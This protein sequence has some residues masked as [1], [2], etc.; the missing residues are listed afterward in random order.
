MNHEGVREFPRRNFLHAFRVLDSLCSWPVV[1]A[2][3]QPTREQTTRGAAKA[4]IRNARIFTGT[5]PA[6]SFRSSAVQLLTAWL[7]AM[8]FCGDMK[9]DIRTTRTISSVDDFTGSG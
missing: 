8:A 9:R 4:T 2:S 1:Y 3:L 7:I 5:A 6:D